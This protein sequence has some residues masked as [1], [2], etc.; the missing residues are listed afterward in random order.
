MHCLAVPVLVE[1]YN[2]FSQGS[3]K[4]WLP[5]SSF[6][7]AIGF[8]FLW[9][10]RDMV[11]IWCGPAPE[12]SY[13]GQ[14]LKMPWIQLKQFGLPVLTCFDFQ[15]SRNNDHPRLICW[16]C[17]DNFNRYNKDEKRL[18][19]SRGWDGGGHSWGWADTA[20]GPDDRAIISFCT[21]ITVDICQSM[22][23]EGW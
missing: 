6:W 13:V 2:I 21:M 11:I 12:L 22:E 20:S 15:R 3:C 4:T 7:I 19:G 14:L 18:V 10:G 9:T 5:F 8:H 23:A 16:S 1:C 17:I